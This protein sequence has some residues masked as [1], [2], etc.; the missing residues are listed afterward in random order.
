MIL[1][2]L[3]VV[4]SQFFHSPFFTFTKR[5]LVLLHFLL[6][7]SASSAYLRFSFS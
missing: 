7:L 5:P 3:N 4:F 2:F 1:G 6:P